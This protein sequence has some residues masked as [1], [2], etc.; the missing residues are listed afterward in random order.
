MAS[1]GKRDAWSLFLFLTVA[2]VPV[3]VPI[4][5]NQSAIV[6]IVSLIG[7]LVFGAS[8][9]VRR[10]PVSIPFLI[11]VFLI[12]IGS[13]IATVN[14]VSPQA[15]ALALVQDVYLFAWFVALVNLLRQGR[16]LTAFRVTWM[17]VAN[18]VAIYGLAMVMSRGHLSIFDLMGPKGARAMGTFYDPNMFAD[19]LVLSLFVVLSLGEEIGRLLRWASIALLLTAIVATKSNGGVTSL[20][21]GLAAWLLARAWT[22]RLS[23]A[24]L[25]ALGLFC[26]TAV[27]GGLWLVKGM[28]F[29]EKTLEGVQ[30]RSVLGRAGHSSEGRIH[31]WQSL[32]QR[33][34]DKPI[35]IG[36][37]NSSE[38]LL[39]AEERERVDSML[40]KEAHNDYLAYLIERGPLALL[41]LLILKLQALGKAASWWR[42]RVSEGH[43]SGAALAAATLAA[44]VA[45][46]MHSITL[47]TLHFRHEWLFLAMVCAMDGMV[48]RARRAE[49]HSRGSFAEPAGR[50]VAAVA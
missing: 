31:I 27:L 50:R 11:P 49:R 44:L 2:L 16:D 9:L 37:G 14:A 47:E 5:P 30:S 25:L 46:S 1:H 10:Q 6:D 41:G 33:Y 15:S 20:S 8:V 22:A 26:A 7:L 36:P 13:L 28:G 24:G 35:G 3:V 19:Y 45:S 12:G 17:W 39:T 40:S 34:A 18:A 4:G 43:R 21:V 38:L 23:P 48:F 32:L 42:R 29:G